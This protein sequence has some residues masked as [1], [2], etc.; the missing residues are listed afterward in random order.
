MKARDCSQP[1][2]QRDSSPSPSPRTRRR[3]ITDSITYAISERRLIFFLLSL[4]QRERIKMRD[5]SARVLQAPTKWPRERY[6]VPPEFDD[7]RSE[8]RQSL[9]WPEI[10]FVPCRVSRVGASHA[11]TH[12]IRW[13][14]S[15]SGNRNLGRTNQRDAVAGIY[16]PRSFDFADVAREYVHNRLRVSG[17]NGPESL[18]YCLRLAIDREKRNCAPLTSILSPQAGRGG[19]QHLGRS[20]F[21]TRS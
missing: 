14:A 3:G 21:R 9:V 16:K 13:Q 17:D 12:P 11:P 2:A 10:P 6:R 7:S 19:W 5:C 1:G 4:S 18:A 8:Q 15:R 20:E